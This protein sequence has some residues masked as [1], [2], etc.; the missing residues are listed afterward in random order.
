MEVSSSFGDGAVASYAPSL[1][2]IGLGLGGVALAGMIVLI[3]IKVLR[4][5][6]V[7]LANAAID[8]HHK[9]VT[10]RP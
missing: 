3:G 4:F 2:E 6:P 10:P 8:P 9:A 5:L 7:S 1:P